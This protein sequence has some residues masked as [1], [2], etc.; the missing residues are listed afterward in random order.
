MLLEIDKLLGVESQYCNEI[1]NKGWNMADC[2]M[3][4]R[5]LMQAKQILKAF[6]K[7]LLT[8]SVQITQLFTNIMM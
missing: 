7:K 2:E 8:S 6:H 3:E 5:K 1:P 4:R